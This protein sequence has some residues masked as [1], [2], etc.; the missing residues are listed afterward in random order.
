M[1]TEGHKHEL[2]NPAFEIA[3]KTPKDWS[4]MTIGVD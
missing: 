4:E 3:E 1:H 2:D